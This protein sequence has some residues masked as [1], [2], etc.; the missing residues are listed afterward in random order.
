[1]A[2]ILVTAIVYPAIVPFLPGIFFYL[3]SFP[4]EKVLAKLV[5][6]SE[7]DASQGADQWYLEK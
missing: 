7:Q 1:L 6:E 2:V 4:M 3:L 5:P